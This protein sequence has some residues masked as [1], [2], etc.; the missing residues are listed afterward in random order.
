[1][2]V[3]RL[4]DLLAASG[5]EE[6]DPEAGATALAESARVSGL[7]EK[8]TI[9]AIEGISVLRDLAM[10]SPER[11]STAQANEYQTLVTA[12]LYTISNARRNV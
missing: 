1:M 12:I 2:V 3:S 9:S 7:I 11:V 10:I 5:A 6:I 4:A 8:Q